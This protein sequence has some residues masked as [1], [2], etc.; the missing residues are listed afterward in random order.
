M[1]NGGNVKGLPGSSSS[2]W[3][4]LLSNLVSDVRSSSCE[5]RVYVSPKV[6]CGKV[7]SVK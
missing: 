6:A 5:K 7:L 3:I 4:F 1:L 2:R